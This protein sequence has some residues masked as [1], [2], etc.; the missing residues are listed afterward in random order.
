MEHVA[1][2]KLRLHF[3]GPQRHSMLVCS[4]PVVLVRYLLPVVLVNQ[5]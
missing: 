2:R 3:V 5:N 4:V 1:S